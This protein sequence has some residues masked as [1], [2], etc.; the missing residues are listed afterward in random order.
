MELRDLKKGDRYVYFP[1]NLQE[2]LVCCQRGGFSLQEADKKLLSNLQVFLVS[3]LRGR[4]FL[5]EVD[6]E[7]LSNLQVFLDSCRRCKL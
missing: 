1:V 4:L 7:R 5:R 3:C 6:E 2:L